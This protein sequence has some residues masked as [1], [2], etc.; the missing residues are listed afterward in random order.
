M[1]ALR[2]VLT[3]LGLLVSVAVAAQGDSL[4]IVQ[5][6]AAFDGAVERLGGEAYEVSSAASAYRHSVS[7][8]SLSLR[9]DMRSEEQALLPAEGDGLDAGRFDAR[10]YL[11]LDDRTT[12]E[13]EAAYMR[14]R[15]HNVLWNSSSDFMLL[16]P[17]ITADSVGGDLTAE[18]YKFGGSYARRGGRFTYGLRASYRALH[19]FRRVDPRPRNVTSDLNADL[20]GGYSAEKYYIGVTAG[21]RMYRQTNSIAYNNPLGAN[22]SQL[23]MTGLGTCFD[24]FAGTGSSSAGYKFRGTGYSFSA[25]LVPFGGSGWSAA[26]TYDGFDVDRLLSSANYVPITALHTDRLSGVAAFRSGAGR[27][28]WGVELAGA[29]GIRRGDENIVDNGAL[30]TNHILGTFT[31]FDARRIAASL[32]GAVE[33]HNNGGCVFFSPR[34]E[35]ADLDACYRYPKRSMT[36][37]T[38]TGGCDFGIE[39]CRERY[40]AAAAIGA[41]YLSSLGESLRLPV[42]TEPAI[43]SMVDGVWRGLTTDKLLLNASIGFEHAAGR[44]LAWSIDADWRMYGSDRGS[45]HLLMVEAGI[46]F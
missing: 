19:E 2:Y 12:V 39:L 13:A 24:R 27:V 38:L 5:R 17:Y 46:K 44:A 36:F 20:S 31:M 14:G 7:L 22:T 42:S 8:S 18:Q 29:Y 3:L 45:G 6:A 32:R 1:R 30:E 10:S 37:T 21:L 16:W 40:T 33:F 43:R 15:K 11:H 25:Q 41:G 26:V 28:R 34:M 35:M 23:P 4:T 9:C